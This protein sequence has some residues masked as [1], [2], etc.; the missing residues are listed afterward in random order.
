MFRRKVSISPT[1]QCTTVDADSSPAARMWSW[2]TLLTALVLLFW[3]TTVLGCAIPNALGSKLGIGPSTVGREA[4]LRTLRGHQDVVWG[5]AFTPDGTVIASASGDKTVRLWRVT[6]GALLREFE[7]PDKVTSVAF[8]PD[9]TIL[10]SGAWDGK[11]RLWQV[12]DGRLLH[13]LKHNDTAVLSVAFSPD[14]ATLVSGAE[15][16]RV[17]LWRAA[18]GTLLHIFQGHQGAVLSVAFAPDGTILGSG[19][20]D[21]TIR[22]W[23]VADERSLRILE[24]Q[25]FDVKSVIFLPDDTILAAG[26]AENAVWLRQ[27]QVSDGTLV[28]EWQYPTGLTTS[29]IFSVDGSILASGDGNVVRMWQVLDG[30]PLRI[31]TGNASSEV[32]AVAFSADGAI[33]ASATTDGS[34]WLWQGEP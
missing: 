19:S 2:K 8:S 22:L 9:G 12:M 3:G 27:W 1:S 29:M 14:G 26:A 33:L 24:G 20:Q 15:D 31:R 18:D 25:A 28:H 5:L 23:S 34:V 21:T 10:A 13:E 4:L 32:S 11:V 17:H 7:H 6:D 30:K 16:S